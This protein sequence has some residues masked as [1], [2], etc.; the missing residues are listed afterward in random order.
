MF[1]L[2][3]RVFMCAF[4]LEIFSFYRQECPLSFSIFVLFQFS[5]GLISTAVGDL[6][7]ISPLAEKVI[8]NHI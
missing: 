4:R 5:Y 6:K 2:C 1:Q 8:R 3:F 7:T